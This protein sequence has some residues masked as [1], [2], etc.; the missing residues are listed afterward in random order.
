V[1]QQV[2]GQTC[3]KSQGLKNFLKKT[4]KKLEQKNMADMETSDDEDYQPS[5]SYTFPFT[6]LNIEQLYK[7]INKRRYKDLYIYFKMTKICHVPLVPF[8]FLVCGI[9]K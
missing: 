2:F 9:M 5:K 3:F 8:F 4:V 1:I 6:L 7:E